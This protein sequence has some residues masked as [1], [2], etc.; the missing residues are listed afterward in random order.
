MARFVRWLAWAAAAGLVAACAAP[1][2]AAPPAKPTFLTPQRLAQAFHLP[3]WPVAG[4]AQAAIDLQAVLDAQT[5][6]SAADVAEANLD[7]TRGP[8][9]WAQDRRALG[10]GFTAERFPRTV[11]LLQAVHDDMRGINNAM[12]AVHAFRPRPYAL[13]VAD[14]RPSLPLPATGRADTSSYPS[15]RTASSRTW[16]LVLAEVFP[17]RRAVLLAQAE[18][19]A[20]L[21]LIGGVHF[22]SDIEAGRQVGDAAFAQ[23]LA[24]P[25]FQA[26]LRLA[27]QEALAVPL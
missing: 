13:G 27:Q 26:A 2:T 16:A 20:Q 24:D 21:R 12:N 3:L 4:S 25:A 7:A 9:A 5:Q 10:S 6:R 17:T 14:L 15:A 1:P 19:S 23:L 22:P 18:R 11:A 8:L